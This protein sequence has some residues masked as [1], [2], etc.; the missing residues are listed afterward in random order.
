LWFG[1][2]VSGE[3]GSDP[4]GSELTT[5]TSSD[6]DTETFTFVL[7]ILDKQ[8]GAVSETSFLQVRQFVCKEH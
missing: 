4:F 6:T 3:N 8:C 1:S 5:E 7:A 2:G